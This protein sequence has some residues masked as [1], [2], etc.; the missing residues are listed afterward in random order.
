[1]TMDVTSVESEPD[2]LPADAL[3]G[4]ASGPARGLSERERQILDFEHQWWREPGAK[5]Q[6]IRDVFD[7]SAIR[8]YQILNTLIDRDEAVAHAPMLVRRLRRIRQQR[9]GAAS[10]VR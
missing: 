4:P 5:D 6:A 8:Y 1:M 3:P 9:R 10:Q 2:L 7:L